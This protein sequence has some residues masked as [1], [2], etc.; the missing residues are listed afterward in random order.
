MLR[1]LLRGCGINIDACILLRRSGVG[2]EARFCCNIVVLGLWYI[3]PLCRNGATITM[4]LPLVLQ[5][6]QSCVYMTSKLWY[7]S[8]CYCVADEVVVRLLWHY[9]GK[10]GTHYDI[11][12]VEG[13]D[14]GINAKCPRRKP[15]Q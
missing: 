9:G 6:H 14:E 8:Y 10:E 12:V 3:S 2:A 7:V 1:L 5:R 4:Y 13:V 15:R 11:V